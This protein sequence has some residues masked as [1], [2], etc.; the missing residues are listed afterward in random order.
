M[1][2]ELDLV[3][4]AIFTDPNDSSAWLYQRWLLD[5][6]MF[7]A[8]DIRQIKVTENSAT[9]IF[10]GNT[11]IKPD[12]LILT[13][14]Y[15]RLD[16][17][18]DHTVTWYSYNNKVH[19]KQWSSNLPAI[20]NGVDREFLSI[21][22]KYNNKSY[23]LHKSKNCN[24]W[25]YKSSIKHTDTHRTQLIEQLNNIEKLLEMEPNNKW[26]L[27]TVILLM[28]NLDPIKYYNEILKNLCTLM[29]IDNLHT[30][31]YTDV[32]KLIIS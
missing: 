28:K 31:Y 19:S 6:N 23:D 22:V 10:H 5:Y 29:K 2:S 24:V 13:R 4:N 16:P 21:F 9:I 17:Y 27:L 12:E 8:N 32:R 7:K 14:K 18:I 25:Y 26:A 15:S 3:I 1:V 20:A 11:E 30:E